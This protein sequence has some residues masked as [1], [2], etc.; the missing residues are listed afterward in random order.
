MA[1]IRPAIA[2]SGVASVV[3]AAPLV[4]AGAMRRSV[5]KVHHEYD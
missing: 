3:V 4:V 5:S 1:I 2:A